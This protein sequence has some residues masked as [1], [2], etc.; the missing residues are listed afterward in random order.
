MCRRLF[1]KEGLC[2][3]AFWGSV[4]SRSRECWLLV[5]RTARVRQG[6]QGQVRR[7]SHLGRNGTLHSQGCCRAIPG[8]GGRA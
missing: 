3:Q 4:L 2:T 1:L 7:P 8:G 6:L 5:A